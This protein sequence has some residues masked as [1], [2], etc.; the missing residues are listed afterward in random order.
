MTIETISII[1][2]IVSVLLVSGSLIFVGM[3]M[4]QTH[5]VERAN[6]QRHLIT[7]WQEWLGIPSQDA[8]MFEDVRECM[9]D[10]LGSPAFKR[11]R[12]FSW[13]FNALWIAEQ[14][15]YQAND[16]LINTAS[17]D[18]MIAATLAIITT[19]GGQQWWA[20]AKQLVGDDIRVYLERLLAGSPEKLPLQWHTI[21]THFKALEMRA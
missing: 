1:I 19:P 8:S 10:Y 21:A 6:A 15:L 5:M 3:Q 20:E 14:G 12:F 11:Q 7:Q 9:H 18:R 13:A 16:R 4:R 2:Q 17:F